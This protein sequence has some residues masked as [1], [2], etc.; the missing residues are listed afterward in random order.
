MGEQNYGKVCDQSETYKRLF[1]DI[2]MTSLYDQNVPTRHT[3]YKRIF[4]DIQMPSLVPF[5]LASKNLN[6]S[7]IRVFR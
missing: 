6:L 4:Y 1:Y 3:S 5:T 2:Q 7:R